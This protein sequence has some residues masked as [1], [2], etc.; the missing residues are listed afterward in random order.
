MSDELPGESLEESI[1]EVPE[2]ELANEDL[3]SALRHL[4]PP[5]VSASIILPSGRSVYVNLRDIS[6]T[7]ACTVRRGALE[8]KENE[9]VLFEVSDFEI[10]QKVSLPSRVQWVDSSGYNTVVGLVF[11]DG[12]LLPG[13]LL[14][15]Y[16]D[17]SLLARGSEG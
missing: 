16:L 14:D 12:P 11:N 17:Q 3:R 6:R 4:L 7:G 5:G 10:Q 2:S 15:A 8:V 9:N 13:T 1:E